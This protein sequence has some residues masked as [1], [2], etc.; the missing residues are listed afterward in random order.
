MVSNKL[1]A[2]IAATVAVSGA[3]AQQPAKKPAKATPATKAPAPEPAASKPAPPPPPPPPFAPV[4]W[5]ADAPITAYVPNET[6]KVYEWISAQVAAVPGKP[7]QFSTT[8]ERRTYEAAVV[9]KLKAIG[10][11]AVIHPCSKK[12]NGDQQAYEVKVS[13]FSIDD[14]MLR[15]PNP[16]A[17]RLRK[18]TI[19]RG[20]VV[21]DTYTGQNAYGANT[22]ISRT[23]SEMFV[24]TFTSELYNDPNSVWV[25]APTSLR[26][27]VPYKLDYGAY[28]FN[29]PMPPADAR[30]QDKSISC[31]S[32]FTV[33]PP[34]PFKF[35]E[36]SRP[37]RDMPFDHTTNFKALM[38]TL[39]MLAVVNTAT[40]QVYAKATRQGFPGQ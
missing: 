29:V 11:L 40:G 8:E 5:Q 30:E 10:P 26:G 7:D 17:L 32:V 28:T 2:L 27:P 39:D 34:G 20:E 12:Y 16:E 38:G 3:L 35:T 24:L 13:G 9:D 14:V 22:E 37:T 6:A 33:S 1:A 36:R 19:G 4:R 15:D 23:V 18:V 25:A 21:K 31:L